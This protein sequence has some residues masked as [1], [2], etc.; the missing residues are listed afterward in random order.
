MSLGLSASVLVAPLLLINNSSSNAILNGIITN[1]KDSLTA[2]EMS[3]TTASFVIGE[4]PANSTTGTVG[5]A[6]ISNNLSSELY[7]LA[8]TLAYNSISVIPV[9]EIVMAETARPNTLVAPAHPVLPPPPP[10]PSYH[11]VAITVTHPAPVVNYSTRYGKASWYAA[12]FGTCANTWLPFGTVLHVTNLGNGA[13]TTCRVEDR[14]PFVGGRVLD[15][16][17]G[18][19]SQIASLGTGV[20]NIRMQW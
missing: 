18:T 17:E 15:L 7:P 16:S 9:G 1:G 19:F 8:S 3:G 14:G 2:Y 12:A 4:A 5:S 6:T 10:P 20:I 11:E 13:T